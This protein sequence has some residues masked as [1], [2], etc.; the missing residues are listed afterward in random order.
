MKQEHATD[1][2]SPGPAA[3]REHGHESIPDL[4]RNLATDL[5]TLLRKE[6]AL[7]KSEVGE[8]VSEAKTAVGALATGG[9][10]AM[11]GLVVLLMSAVYGLSNV[12]EPWLAALIVG[13][14]ALVVGYMLVASAK[15]NMSATSIVPDRTMDSAKKDTETVKRATR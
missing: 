7:A 3:N 9:A 5:S 6:V 11:A 4:V 14:V 15:K 12:V 13:A 8:S 2:V 10:V 1:A